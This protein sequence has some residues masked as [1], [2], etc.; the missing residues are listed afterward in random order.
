[1]QYRQHQPFVFWDQV[2]RPDHRL[3]VAL[4]AWVKDKEVCFDI[5]QDA[6]RAFMRI[7]PLL[8][9]IVTTPLRRG[10]P[11]VQAFGRILWREIGE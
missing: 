11:G 7:P 6:P 3:Q 8:D 2:I 5:A 1:M 4:Q 9:S 10:D